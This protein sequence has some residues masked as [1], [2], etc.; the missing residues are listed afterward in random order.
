MKTAIRVV[1]LLLLASFPAVA[2]Q[3]GVQDELLDHMAGNWLMSGTIGGT[4]VTHD[5][6]AEW[7]LGHQ[8]LRFHEVSR[9]VDSEVV[10]AYEAI[11]FIGWDQRTSRYTCLWLDVTGSGA[12]FPEAT[13]YAEPATD[14]L[15]F[16]FD[17]GD[18]SVIHTTF[19]YDREADAWHWLIVIDRGATHSTFAQVSLT[20][21]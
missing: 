5:L 18:A 2:G 4:Q 15:A 14:E 3:Q 17:T 6:A 20:R 7:V 13:G 9:E 1:T 11:V 12:Q 8:Y 21:K 19:T 10:P 16:V